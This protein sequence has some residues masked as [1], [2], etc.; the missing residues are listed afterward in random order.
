MAWTAQASEETH[1]RDKFQERKNEGGRGWRGDLRKGGRRRL[2]NGRQGRKTE[3][4]RRGGGG[5]G[6]IKGGN[7]VR[8]REREEKDLRWGVFNGGTR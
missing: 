1:K 2:R 3:R 6:G 7:E 8:R 5:E 4:R